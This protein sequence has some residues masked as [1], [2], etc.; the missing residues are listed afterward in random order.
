MPNLRS[1]IRSILGRDIS[2]QP[3]TVRPGDD[4]MGLTGD[5]RVLQAMAN[6]HGFL[7]LKAPDGANECDMSVLES[8]MQTCVAQGKFMQT[9]HT[10]LA[11][12]RVDQK[13]VEAITEAERALETAAATTTQR[14]K[15]MVG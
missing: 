12:G 13:E 4:I 15:G 3:A 6:K 9:I 2:I 10:A 7:L 1:F 14:M 11:D 5:F 8:A